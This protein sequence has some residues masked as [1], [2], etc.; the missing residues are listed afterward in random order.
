MRKFFIIFPEEDH[1]TGHETQN[2]LSL[3]YPLFSAVIRVTVAVF[4]QAYK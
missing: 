3:I 2:L 4:V 1:A